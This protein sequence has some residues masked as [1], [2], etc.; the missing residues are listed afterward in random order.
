[1]FDADELDSG[2]LGT[3]GGFADPVLRGATFLGVLSAELRSLGELTD[4]MVTDGVAH[5]LNELVS[6]SGRL[7]R[8]LSMRLRNSVLYTLTNKCNVSDTSSMMFNR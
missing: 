8:S 2:K 1:V 3:S 7:S 4:D 5:R 6:F